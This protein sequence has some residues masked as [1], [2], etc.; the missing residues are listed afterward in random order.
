M[1]IRFGVVGTGHWAR[2][3]HS[4]GIEAHPDVELVATWGR[5]DDFDEFLSGVDAVT[6]AVPPHVQAPLA[7]RAAEAGKH[8][9]LEKPIA[10][11]VATADQLVAAAADVSTVVFFTSR[12]VEAW[13]D[14]FDEQRSTPLLGGRAEWLV[15]LEPDGPYG[16]S[17]WRK[18]EGALWDV[19]PHALSYLLPALGPVVSVAGARGRG[20][21]VELVLSHEG[22]ATSTMALSSTMPADT[23][24][25]TVELYGEHGFRPRPD[26]PREVS[27]C[28]ARALSELLEN[29][30]VGETAHRCDV[31]F[32][33]EVVDVLSRCEE[34]LARK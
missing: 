25:V 9:L 21:L 33:R 11:D 31:R 22:G 23:T 10:A 19:G 14:W 2:T 5:N 30:A 26:S 6:F 3:V 16:N 1:M 29:I 17:Q 13:E 32:G 34:V 7:I 20:D 27:A 12:F 28:Y 18:T 15:L 8:L 24:R 4:P